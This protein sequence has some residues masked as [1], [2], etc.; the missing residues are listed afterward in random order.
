M[1]LQIYNESA[2][3]EILLPNVIDTDYHIK[4]RKSVFHLSEDITLLLEKASDDWTLF[5]SREYLVFNKSNPIRRVKIKNQMVL[6]IRTHSKGEELYILTADVPVAFHLMEKYDISHIREISIG[7]SSESTICYSNMNLIS[8]THAILRRGVN[9]WHIVDTSDNGTFIGNQRISEDHVLCFGD[10]IEIFGLHLIF[11]EPYL[12]LGNNCGNL[13][14]DNKQLGLLQINPHITEEDSVRSAIASTENWFNRSPREVPSLFTENIEIKLPPVQDSQKTA[15]TYMMFIP[16]FTILILMCI[17][18]MMCIIPTH[19]VGGVAGIILNIGLIITVGS[20]IVGDIW[21]I[22]NMHFLNKKDLAVYAQRGKNHIDYLIQIQG[23]IQKQYQHNKETLNKMYPSAEICVQYGRDD[24][25]LWNRNANHADFLYTR[26]GLGDSPFQVNLS[27]Q[28]DDRFLNNDIIA[29]KPNQ[30]CEEFSILHDVPVGINLLQYGLIGIV[31]GRG[32]EGAITMMQ[33]I[34]ANIVAAHCYTDVKLVFVFDEEAVSDIEDWECMRWFPHVWSEDRRTRYF[35]GNEIERRDIFFELSSI[36]MT[37]G[38]NNGSIVHEN[39]EQARRVVKPHY[40]FFISDPD[41]IEGESIMKYIYDVKPAYGLTTFLMVETIQ[42]LPNSCETIIQ[43]NDFGSK[44]YNLMDI[45]QEKYNS[46][47]PDIISRSALEDFARRLANIKV[48]ETSANDEIP[49]T[50]SFLD[51]FRVNTLQEL[52]IQGRWRNNKVYDS[53]KVLIGRKAGNTD[54]FLDIHEKFHGPHGLVAGTTGSG[55]SEILQTYILSLA[56][57]FSPEDVGFFIIDFKGGGM[58]NLFSDLPHLVGQISNLSGNQVS[59]AMISIE[60]EIKRR[61]RIFEWNGVNNINLYTLLYKSHEAKV[62]MPH[63]FII[64]DEFAELRREE[65]E[66]MQYLISVAQIGRSLGVHLI[67]ATQKPSGTVDDNIWANSKFRLCLRVQDRQDSMDMLHKPD[68][69]LLTQ[70]GRCFLQ[71]GNDEIFELFQSGFSGAIYTEGKRR[72]SATTSMI[73]HIGKIDLAGVRNKGVEKTDFRGIT[74][75]DAVIEYLNNIFKNTD[76][77]KSEPLWL[78]VLPETLYLRDLIEM[79][80]KTDPESKNLYFDGESWAASAGEI[81]PEEKYGASSDTGALRVRRHPGKWHLETIIGLYD[82]PEQQAQRPLRIDFTD[83]GHLAV[84]GQ[85]VSGKSTFL[86]SLIYGLINRYT[87]QALQV[88]LLDFSS[89]MLGCFADA[90]HVGGIVTDVQEDR[91]E[92]FFHMLSTLMDERRRTLQG[93]NFAQYVQAYGMKLPAVLVVIDNYA[94]FRTKTNDKYDDV[95][96]RLSR[97]G[98]GYGIFLVV[99]AAGFGINDIPSR[100]GDNLRTI[101]SLEQPDKFKYMET[102]RRTHLQIIPETNVKGRGLALVDDRPLEFQTV[103]CMEAE[104]DFSRGQKIAA[105]CQQMKDAWK[106]ESARRIPEI[107]ENP[108]LEILE[109]DYRYRHALGE[110]TLLPFGYFAQDASIASVNLLRNYCFMITGRARSGKTNMLRLLLHAASKK[111]A[112]R[113]II[114]KKSSEFTDFE[115]QAAVYDARYVSDGKEMFTYFSELMPEFVRRNK[116]KRSLIESGMDEMDI[117]AKMMEEKPIFIFIAD[118]NDFMTMVY[119]KEAGIGDVSGFLENI[120]EKGAMH[121]IFFFAC[122]RVEDDMGLRGYSAYNHFCSYR[123]GVHLGGN[124]I[125][126]RIFNFQNIPFNQMNNPLKK[127]FGHMSSYEDDNIG[128][129]VVIPMAK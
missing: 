66:F 4:L 3:K 125:G 42:Q 80:E 121:N 109:T 113:V 11:M 75:L 46:F 63:L 45:Q 94:G 40:V 65:P 48:R 59:R 28:R 13:T 108:T 102:I 47:K 2:Y 81:L 44:L 126:Q 120:M 38:E 98:V 106:G 58:A 87:P 32:R 86:Q 10:K 83:G 74:Q 6:K 39:T 56:V 71:V 99:S 70:V 88:Y 41:I 60:S 25:R 19:P 69:A 128:I 90:P 31:G 67:L 95:L 79:M 93:G 111:D 89:N 91:Q 85:V 15:Q 50:I 20:A 92:K 97:E 114:E 107:P 122:L 64:I 30:I 76:Y 112:E 1:I 24:A 35:A 124:L 22:F 51:L 16:A 115:K 43:N 26:L 129:K 100:I 36:L 62:P 54:C 12:L 49:T 52:N 34:V 84:C 7:Q 101:I 73:G 117:A 82:N 123:K 68:A 118:M 33:T 104:D 105:E 61:Q 5:E 23:N 57:N 53:M 78:P 110:Q 27:V 72:L 8:N 18:L 55:K 103:L 9:G 119:K 77:K 14:V 127:G 21:A 96:L 29:D 37:R 116:I 17:G